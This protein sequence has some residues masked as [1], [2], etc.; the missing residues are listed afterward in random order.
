MGGGVVGGA[1]V[2]VVAGG[3]WVVVGAAVEVGAT[4]A[5]VVG[6][7]AVGG[8][9]VTRGTVV[10]VAARLGGGGGVGATDN[11]VVVSPAAVSVSRRVASALRSSRSTPARGAVA[12]DIGSAGGAVVASLV[13]WA[14]PTATMSPAYAPTA[15]APTTRRA[16]RAG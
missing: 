14:Q 4:A 3:A 2:V 9:A 15:V 16:R 5:V 7:G 11:E 1:I 10:V 12:S 6:G 13:R 8:G